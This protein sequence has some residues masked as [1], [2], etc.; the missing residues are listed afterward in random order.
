MIPLALL[1]FASSGG[2]QVANPITFGTITNI[3][4]IIRLQNVQ[5]TTLSKRLAVDVLTKMIPLTP[6]FAG[7]PTL[8]AN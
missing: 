7:R 1:P 5:F 8:K 3:E 2:D 4:E 6:D